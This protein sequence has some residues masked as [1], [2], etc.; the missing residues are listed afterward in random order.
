MG[1][2]GRR[3]GE[4]AS[5]VQNVWLSSKAGQQMDIRSCLASSRSTALTNPSGSLGDY[6]VTPVNFLWGK[7]EAVVRRDPQ[8]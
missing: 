8:C 1:D 7:W 5:I 3:R 2:S 6:E 4:K